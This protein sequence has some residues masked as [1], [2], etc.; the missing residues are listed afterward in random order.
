M[1]K[2]EPLNL[3]SLRLC[4]E[5]AAKL[6]QLQLYQNDQISYHCIIYLYCKDHGHS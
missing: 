5:S 6:L 3:P 4:S 2:G 1:A